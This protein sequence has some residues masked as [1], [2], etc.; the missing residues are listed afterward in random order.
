MEPASGTVTQEFGTNRQFAWQ[1]WG[2]LGR[3]Y[4]APTGTPC[5]AIA[6]GTVIFADWGQ[7]LA[8]HLA[9]EMQIVP[10]SP[11]SGICVII[12]HDGWRSLYAHLSATDLNAGDRVKRGDTV[13]KVGN[14]GNSLGPH[15]HF[16]VFLTPSPAAAPF[17]RYDP[18]LQVDYENRRV[19]LQSTKPTPIKEWSDMATAEEFRTVI[20]EEIDRRLG[21]V[22][23]VPENQGTAESR[24][25]NPTWYFPNALSRVWAA[26]NSAAR[27]SAQALAI[28]RRIAEK[29]GITQAEVKAAVTEALAENVVNVNIDVQGKA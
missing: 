11:N 6:A 27:D 26:S 14:T 2:H 16:E 24:K 8:T 12:Q 17:G 15:L 13:G 3:D 29:T 22:I 20:R 23:A 21:D 10:G 28:V 25:A 19:S 5:R 1:P 7:N 18:R 9:N 4:G